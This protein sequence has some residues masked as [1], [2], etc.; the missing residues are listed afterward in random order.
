MQGGPKKGDDL[1]WLTL[2]K[3]M[4]F[5]NFEKITWLLKEGNGLASIRILTSICHNAKISTNN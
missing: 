5:G 1:F 3:E 2:L 4:K